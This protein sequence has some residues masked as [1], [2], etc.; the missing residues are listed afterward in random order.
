MLHRSEDRRKLT[1]ALNRQIKESLL[2]AAAARQ[3]CAHRQRPV[4]FQRELGAGGQ[5]CG[6]VRGQPVGCG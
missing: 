5:N 2:L 1:P 3:R 6:T 4:Q